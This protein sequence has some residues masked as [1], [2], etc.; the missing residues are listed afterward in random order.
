M[1]EL[2]VAIHEHGVQFIDFEDEALSFDRNWFRR[3]LQAI[4]TGFV[5]NSLELRAMNGLYP[6][7]LDLET[8]VLMQKAGFRVLNLSLGSSK[9]KQ[10]ERFNRPYVVSAFEQALI[11]AEKVGM[12]AV[13]YI[14]AGAPDQNP[15]ESLEDLLFLAQRRVLAGVSIFYPS[16]G[17]ADFETCRSLNLLPA[18]PSLFRSSAF[19]ISHATSR[20]DAATLLRFARILNFMKSLIDH[21]STIPEPIPFDAEQ[22]KNCRTQFEID[23]MLLQGF[24]YDG[25]V[26]GLTAAGNTYSHQVSSSLAR[27][28]IEG[29]KSITIR[30]CK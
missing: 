18:A 14:I 11:L 6:P 20:R 26:R 7:S 23:I 12:E 25:T 13:G 8:V 3:L 4:I 29:L 17:S 16:P 10:L 2:S 15:M 27:R 30:G 24:L 1:E 22:L 9:K 19:P 28:F 21:G 5:K